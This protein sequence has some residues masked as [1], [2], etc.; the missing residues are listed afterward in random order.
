[1][2][3]TKRLLVIA[4]VLAVPLWIAGSAV[5]GVDCDNPKFAEN[6]QCTTTTVP[7]TT[8]TTTASPEPEPQF[9]DVTMTRVGAEGLDTTIDCDDGD[10]VAGSLRMELRADGLYGDAVVPALGLFVAE[11]DADRLFPEPTS[12]VVG[13]EGCH[14]GDASYGGLVITLDDAGAVTDLL[15]HFDYYLDYTTRGKRSL[16]SVMEHFTLSGHDLAW[17]AETS[18]VSGSFDVLYHLE[19]RTTNTSVGYEPVAGSP[20]FL[21]FTVTWTPTP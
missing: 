16:L 15:W 8:T 5:G 17:D 4:A 2:K 19:D 13:F 10:G 12:D 21:E 18:T 6:P 11:V 7:E 3:T 9:V 20:R 14:S 1:M